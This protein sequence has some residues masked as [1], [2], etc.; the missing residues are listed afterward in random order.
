MKIL[1]FTE[2]DLQTNHFGIISFTLI[3]Q[4]CIGSIACAMLLA[5]HL[6]T[7]WLTTCIFATMGA[8]VS[9]ISQAPTKWVIR[10]FVAC[11]LINLLIMLLCVI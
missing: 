11:V 5:A 8:D 10:A 6:S 1:D 7:F 4:S 9:V 2:Q 3:V